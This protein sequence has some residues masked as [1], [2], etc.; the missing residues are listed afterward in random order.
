MKKAIIVLLIACVFLLS[1]CNIRDSIEEA[2]IYSDSFAN[3]LSNDM[4]TIKEYMHT[5]FWPGEERLEVYIAQLER[6]V[7]IDFSNGVDIIS[8]EWNSYVGFTSLYNG[9]VHRHNY[10]LEV[11]G[12]V[13]C[14]YIV[15]LD[16]NDGYG[17]LYFGIYDPSL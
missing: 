9:T 5:D 1:G 3:S 17:V 14:M 6:S 12:K 8:C 13:I 2:K 15:I 11:S 7:G 4:A 10:E 16:N